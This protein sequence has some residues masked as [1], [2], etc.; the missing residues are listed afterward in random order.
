MWGKCQGELPF[1][2]DRQCDMLEPMMN[3]SSPE[4]GKRVRPMK[5]YDDI[6]EWYDQWIGTHSM[7]EEPFVSAECPPL[8]IHEICHT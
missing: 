5:T 4:P 2:G 6:A 7:R 8:S 3:E 1:K